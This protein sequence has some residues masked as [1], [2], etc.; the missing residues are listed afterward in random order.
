MVVLPT[1]PVRGAVS[2]SRE[3]RLMLYEFHALSE[4]DAVRT[5]QAMNLYRLQFLINRYFRKKFGKIRTFGYKHVD[6][7]EYI[8]SRCDEILVYA[9]IRSESNFPYIRKTCRDQNQQNDDT[10]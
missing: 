5:K 8:R 7:K 3:L 6:A 4:P 9:E 10:W 1:S 2:T